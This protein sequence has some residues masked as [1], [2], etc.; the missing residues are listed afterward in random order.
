MVAG[1]VVVVVD[2]VDDVELVSGTELVVVDEVV[3]V[4]DVEDVL[5]DD[6]DDVDDVLLVEL[7]DVEDVDEVED[8]VVV[9]TWH[10]IGAVVVALGQGASCSLPNRIAPMARSPRMSPMA[11]THW[12]PAAIWADVG[13]HG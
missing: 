11:S 8:E 4:D 10:G 9:V 12:S 6:V 1:C 2:D 3:L 5:V 7:D 13:G